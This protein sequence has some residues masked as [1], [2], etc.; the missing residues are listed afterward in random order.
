MSPLSITEISTG[1]SPFVT[2]MSPS[3][4]LNTDDS[5]SP[6]VK[7][8]KHNNNTILEAEEGLESDSE[9]T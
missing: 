6:D 9:T 1:L 8:K 4:M 5:P 2:S 7:K 3:A